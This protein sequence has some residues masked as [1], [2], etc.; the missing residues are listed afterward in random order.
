LIP[1]IKISVRIKTTILFASL[2][3]MLI[4]FQFSKQR[5][6]G[7][8]NWQ[9]VMWSDMAGYYVYLPYTFIYRGDATKVDDDLAE[10]YG[11]GFEIEDGKIMTKYSCGLAILEAPAFLIIH[12]LAKP[13]GYE[14]NGFSPIY[15]QVLNLSVVLYFL[16]GIWFLYHFLRKFISKTASVL[17]ILFVVLAS[18]L[19]YYAIENTGMSHVYSFSLFAVFLYYLKKWIDSRH[20][21]FK[22]L[23]FVFLALS[24]IVLIRPTNAIIII[25][26]FFFEIKN[27]QEFLERVKAVFNVKTLFAGIAILFIVWLPQFIYWKHISGQ[28]IYYSYSEEGFSNKFNPKFLEVWFS[29][30]A[31]LFPYSTVFLLIISSFIFLFKKNIVRISIVLFLL[32]SY[33]TASWHQ[34][35]FGC[36]FGSRNFIDYLPL[37]SL[38]I[39]LLTSRILFYPKKYL[40]IIFVA[41]LIVSAF[42]SQKL[43]ITFNKCYFGDTWE[44]KEYNRMVTHLPYKEKL[45]FNNFE[46]N[47]FG[48]NSGVS[49]SSSIKI[50]Q[51]K[52]TNTNFRKGVVKLN[53]KTKEKL[54]EVYIVSIVS[55]NDSILSYKY[56]KLSQHL[57]TKTDWQ[58]IRQHFF[59]PM[60]IDRE[61]EINVYIWNKSKQNFAIDD[62]SLKLF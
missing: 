22:S 62:F 7:Y 34:P 4:F 38:P 9:S 52:V 6:L 59:L 56:F 5:D 29:P 32:V 3:G 37:F 42:F 33:M 49:I 17:S 47:K 21:H 45:K 50:N 20:Q 24:L 23:I 51:E 46:H 35:Y 12:A 58:K 26:L 2:A 48:F 18:N 14:N 55:K 53:V 39:G 43:F 10:R 16:I 31:G 44:W 11:R 1:K 36:S 57:K 13:L 8:E 15:T 27:K 19:S 28:Y 30:N 41:F 60:D 54:N 40:K 25:L 61:S